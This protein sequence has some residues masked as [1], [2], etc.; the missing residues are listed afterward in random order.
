MKLHHRLL[1]L[2]GDARDGLRRVGFPKHRLEHLTDLAR[3]DTAKKR[4]QDQIVHRL[5]A[6][7]IAR[8]KLRT[9]AFAGARHAQPAE[10]AELGHQIAKIEAVAKIQPADR[11]MLVITKVE[12]AIPFH[13]QG[14]LDQAFQLP[15]NHLRQLL[16]EKLLAVRKVQLKMAV[17]EDFQFSH[18]GVPPLWVST[19]EKVRPFFL[20]RK[21]NLHKRSYATLKVFC[22]CFGW[23]GLGFPR[24]AKTGKRV[25]NRT[26][27]TAGE[28]ESRGDAERVGFRH[29]L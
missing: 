28:L 18:Q 6:T 17:A 1:Q 3:G 9:E 7:L 26:P 11:G 27:P 24:E 23:N 12:M 19:P 5:L 29:R 14:F 22:K 25:K 2:A 16:G 21:P 4:L 10:H 20:L 8:Q 15:A 13:Q